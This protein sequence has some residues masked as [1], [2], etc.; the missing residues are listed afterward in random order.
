VLLLFYLQCAFSD[1]TINGNDANINNICESELPVCSIER[2]ATT[3]TY[4]VYY[5]P[6]FTGRA[7]GI[8]FL[9]EQAGVAYTLESDIQGVTAKHPVCFACP[10]VDDGH[11]VISQT[12]AVLYYLGKKLGFFPDDHNDARALQISL[13]IADLWSEG[14]EAKKKDGGAEWIKTRFSKW[15][16]SLEHSIQGKYFFGEKL[17]YVDFQALNLV[18]VFDFI[19]GHVATDEWAK[20][21]KISA[22]IKEVRALKGVHA[23]VKKGI[24]VLYESVKAK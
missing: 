23:V 7:E 6:G 15:A 11:T 16:N 22:W 24:P 21:P 17:T 4:K 12:P 18:N 9:L 20:Y 13:N 3:S 14:Y 5:W 19:Y 1:N 10:V 2:M 8:L